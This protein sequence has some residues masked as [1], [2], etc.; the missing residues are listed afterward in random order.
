M[1][2]LTINV[3]WSEEHLMN[4]KVFSPFMRYSNEHLLKLDLLAL[5]S[6]KRFLFN[7]KKALQEFSLFDYPHILQLTASGTKMS[8]ESTTANE[9]KEILQFDQSQAMKVTQSSFL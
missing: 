8:T 5:Y 7:L 3:K 4:S 9:R 6:L 2:G 1:E